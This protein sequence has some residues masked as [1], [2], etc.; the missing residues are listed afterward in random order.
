MEDHS[1][2]PELRRSSVQSSW[3]RERRPQDLQRDVNEMIHQPP[4]ASSQ[5]RGGKSPNLPLLRVHTLQSIRPFSACA[6]FNQ[7]GPFDHVCTSINQ[8]LL[9]LR[10]HQSSKQHAQHPLPSTWPWGSPPSFHCVISCGPLFPLSQLGQQGPTHPSTT[11]V[12]DVLGCGLMAS[13]QT[14]GDN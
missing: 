14:F 1:A 7:T 8:A 5:E 3:S 11:F 13:D 12:Y 4:A 6:H 10:S 2:S 9:C